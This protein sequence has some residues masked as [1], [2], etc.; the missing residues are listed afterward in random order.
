MFFYGTYIYSHIKLYAHWW[1]LYR[2]PKRTCPV[3]KYC[4]DIL[5]AM[6]KYLDLNKGLIT[7]FSKWLCTQLDR[8]LTSVSAE[9]T[10]E[11]HIIH[12]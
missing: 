7:V 6:D 2:I 3:L 8:A 10:S 11:Q 1:I 5:G 12:I 9:N 4:F